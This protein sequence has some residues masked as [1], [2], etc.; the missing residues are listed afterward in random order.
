MP[1]FQFTP[2]ILPSEPPLQITPPIQP[3]I[4]RN[5]LPPIQPLIQ[6]PIQPPIQPNN[7]PPIQPPIQPSVKITPPIQPTV[8]NPISQ[9][10]CT[11]TTPL[12]DPNVVINMY[13]ECC[14]LSKAGR[15]AVRL[16]C[17]AYF[18]KEVLVKCTENKD[19]LHYRRTN[20]MN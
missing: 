10:T 11:S 7:L 18:G 3:P 2:L 14:D 20:C 5:N 6:P 13:P 15:M 16:A 8:H 9:H 12:K 1:L 19:T 17:E 4:Q